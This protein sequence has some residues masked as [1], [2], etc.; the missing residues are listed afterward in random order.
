MLFLEEPAMFMR[1]SRFARYVRMPLCITALAVTT[2]TAS[3]AKDPSKKTAAS[4]QTMK[5]DTTTGFRGQKFGTEFSQFQNLTLD[6][7]EGDLK[8]YTKKTRIY[9]SVR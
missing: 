7:D 9:N 5:L 4:E 8:L 1:K 2:V 6:R 3:F